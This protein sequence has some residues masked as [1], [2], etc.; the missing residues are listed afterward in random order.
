MV[1]ACV[2]AHAPSKGIC[3]DLLLMRS[4]DHACDVCTC[5][6]LLP[7]LWRGSLLCMFATLPHTYGSCELDTFAK[8]WSRSAS[9]FDLWLSLGIT[10]PSCPRAVRMQVFSPSAHGVSAS[11]GRSKPLLRLVSLLWLKRTVTLWNGLVDLPDDHLY[12]QVLRD[13][14]YY[15]LPSTL[16][17]G[18]GHSWRPLEV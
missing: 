10:I 15:E 3:L 11:P 5:I 12:S 1:D 16:P 4:N 9:N 18:H 2:Y 7:H 8:I 13:S 6:V 17:C 14:C